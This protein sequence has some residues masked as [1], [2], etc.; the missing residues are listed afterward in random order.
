MEWQTAAYIESNINKK[1]T[2]YLSS[3]WMA[4]GIAAVIAV[5][6]YRVHNPVGYVLIPSC[7][8]WFISPIIAC[9]ISKYRKR[10]SMKLSDEERNLLR[11]IGRKTFAYFEDFVNDEE[12]WLAPDNYQEDPLKGVAHRT[13]PT[14]MGMGI[15]S[16]L[17]GYDLGYITLEELLDRLDK[18]LTNMESL[19]KYKGHFY[20]WYD[21]RSK[22][23]LH[24]RYIST[25][26]SGN[27][28][29]YLWL[30]SKALEEYINQP[31]I[32]RR[33]TRG[34][35]DI[36][37]LSNEEIENSFSVKNHYNNV[38]AELENPN[39]EVVS[40]KKILY[41]ILSDCERFEKNNKKYLYIG[42]LKQNIK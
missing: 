9:L 13:S 5:M 4:S 21:T 6:A 36:L 1:F 42:I 24:P 29:G 31:L 30:T 28:V 7:V 10:F 12:N 15:T 3:M 2:G 40:W 33:Y 18:I 19:E 41:D 11:R 20:N 38:I 37:R 26:D 17:V 34:L 14:N 8:L 16:N 23:P 35:C 22:L 25:V 27:L 39:I 32:G